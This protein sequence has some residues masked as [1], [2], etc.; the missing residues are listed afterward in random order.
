MRL[1]G[2]GVRHGCTGAQQRHEPTQR[3][4]PVHAQ[5][6]SFRSSGHKNIRVATPASHGTAD[7]ALRVLA[8]CSSH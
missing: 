3:V 8:C 6:A 7:N 5:H 2:D 1:G 4:L